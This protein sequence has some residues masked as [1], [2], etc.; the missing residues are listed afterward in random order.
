[1]QRYTMVFITT[2]ALR[3]SGVSCAHHQQLKLYAQHRVFVG[4]FLLLTAIM[5]ELELCFLLLS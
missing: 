1:M 3:V 4:L 5:S 2:N